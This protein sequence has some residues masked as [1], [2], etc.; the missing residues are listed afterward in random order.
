MNDQDVP[1]I[2]A[3]IGN[4]LNQERPPQEAA[5]DL[6]SLLLEIDREKKYYGEHTQRLTEL[7]M[8]AEVQERVVSRMLDNSIV[9]KDQPKRPHLIVVK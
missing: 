1:N 6:G 7:K 9:N 3:I 2:V 5:A 4:A 8:L